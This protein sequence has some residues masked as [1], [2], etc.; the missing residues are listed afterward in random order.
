MSYIFLFKMYFLS[1]IPLWVTVLFVDIKS[2]IDNQD[3]ICTEIISVVLILLGCF[4]CWITP[5]EKHKTFSV[6]KYELSAVKECKTVNSEFLLSYILPLFAFDFTQWDGVVQFLIFFIILGYLCIRHNYFSVNI[7]LELK[8]FKLYEC[9]LINSDGMEI[10]RMV[11]SKQP[12]SVKK[13]DDVELKTINNDIF[14]DET[15]SDNKN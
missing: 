11:I 8:G 10:D 14:I 13:G 2:M 6:E 7:V 1:F 3:N 12:L 9:T 5:I 4:V 15:V